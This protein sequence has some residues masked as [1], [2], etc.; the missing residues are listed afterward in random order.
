MRQPNQVQIQ[1]QVHLPNAKP[2]VEITLTKIHCRLIMNHQ[3]DMRRID[4]P[5]LFS[6]YVFG[7]AITPPAPITGSAMKAAI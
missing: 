3:G 2:S 7:G 6:K 5:Y 4:K 1:S